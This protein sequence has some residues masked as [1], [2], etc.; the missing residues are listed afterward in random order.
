MKVN[1]KRLAE[2]II[3]DATAIGIDAEHLDDADPIHLRMAVRLLK[4]ARRSLQLARKRSDE[5]TI[6]GLR[7]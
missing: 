1:I 6:G 4:M 2:L 3:V 5:H 7:R